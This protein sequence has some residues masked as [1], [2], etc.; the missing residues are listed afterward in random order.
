ML[1]NY[2]MDNRLFEKALKLSKMSESLD[3]GY[4]KPEE[5]EEKLRA[6]KV[7]TE[8]VYK[9]FLAIVVVV[10]GDWKHDH[11]WCDEVMEKEFDLELLKTKTLEENGTDFYKA[12]RY[13]VSHDVAAMG[14]LFR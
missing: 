7:S 9:D 2:S 10:K 6:E 4:P 1:S 12:A 5:V 11:L 3:E 13:Y 8:E 14:A